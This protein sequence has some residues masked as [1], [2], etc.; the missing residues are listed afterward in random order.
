M[1]LGRA[2]QPTVATALGALLLNV[3]VRMVCTLNTNMKAM[4]KRMPCSR[5]FEAGVN[6]NGVIQYADVHLYGDNG[7]VVNEPLLALGMDVYHN[8][9][10]KDLFNYT[11]YNVITDTASNTWCRSPGTLENIAMAELMIERI[12][13]E[14]GLDP[15]DVRMANLGDDTREDITKM[16]DTLI[17]NSRYYERKAAVEKFNENNR[18]TKRGIRLCLLRWEPVGYMNLDVTLTVCADDGTVIITHGGIEMGQGV[19][20]KAIQIASYILKVPVEKIQ[21]KANSNIAVPNCSPSGGSITSQNVGIGVRKCCEELLERLAP[22]KSEMGDPTWVQLIQKAFASQVQLR[23]TCYTTLADMLKYHICGA[24][25][26][27]VQ[28]DILTGEFEIIKTEMMVDCGQSINPG[29]DC[30]Q[31]EG[32]FL[33]GIG[34][35]TSENLVY[36]SSTGECVSDRSWY[37]W[38][39]QAC[40]I[41]QSSTLMFK[42]RGYSSEIVYGA[43][44]T[45][46]PATCMSVVVMFA[47]RAAIEAARTDCGLNRNEW[48][49]I[50]GSMTLEKL[51]LAASSSIQDFKI[52][53]QGCLEECDR[54]SATNGKRGNRGA[55]KPPPLAAFMIIII[56]SEISS[57]DTLLE[58]LRRSLQLRGTKYNCLEGGCGACIVSVIKRDGEAP[59]GVNSVCIVNEDARH[60]IRLKTSLIRPCSEGPFA[61]I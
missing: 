52:K 22:I 47:L 16:V 10:N 35:W 18:W 27:E 6:K 45:G 26:A 32:A 57:S 48:Y 43:K 14:L 5:Y 53:T 29:I 55:G 19:N 17:K 2:N 34:Y 30:G 4:G 40:D 33:M 23:V 1:K 58:V 61:F 25:M 44:G 50:D 36:D 39:P 31:I 59:Q 41:P 46:E 28:V 24:A 15:L 37:Y 12:A 13:C 21:V 51:C 60:I 11:A 42:P 7:W 8:C 54:L 38:P 3:P 20:A 9:Y 56:G 49:T